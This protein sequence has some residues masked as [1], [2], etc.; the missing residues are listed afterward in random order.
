MRPFRV[1]I[2]SPKDGIADYRADIIRATRIVDPE[3]FDFF[4]YEKQNITRKPGQ[5]IHEAI[6]EVA[7]TDF[8]AIFIFFK[9]RVGRGTINEFDFFEKFILNNNPNCE[10]WWAQIHCSRTPKLVSDF[11]GRISIRELELPTIAGEELIVTP[12]MLRGRF[13]AKVMEVAHRPK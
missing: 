3:K 13:T 7:G 5:E 1:F 4:Y 6:F 11:I 9:D 10:I 2:S 8:D 12:S